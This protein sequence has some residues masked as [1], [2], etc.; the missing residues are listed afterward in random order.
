M[1][2]FYHAPLIYLNILKKN[3]LNCEEKDREL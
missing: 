3:N 2:Y 1:F